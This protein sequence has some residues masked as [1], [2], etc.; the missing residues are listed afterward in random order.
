MLFPLPDAAARRRLLAQYFGT[1]IASLAAEG[2]GDKQQQQRRRRWWWRLRQ[3]ARIT[4][5]K[6]E[7]ACHVPLT[8]SFNAWRCCVVCVCVCTAAPQM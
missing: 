7:S 4:V 3:G 2:A 1:Y 8:P 6:G 5:D